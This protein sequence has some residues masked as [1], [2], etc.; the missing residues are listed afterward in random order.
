MNILY[1]F[2]YFLFAHSLTHTI[3]VPTSSGSWPTS[4]SLI[5]SF[6]V[7]LQCIRNG[8]PHSTLPKKL[9]S[10]LL[11]DDRYAIRTSCVLFVP[12]G[13]RLP[14]NLGEVQGLTPKVILPCRSSHLTLTSLSKFRTKLRFLSHL[15]YAG[16]RPL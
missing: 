12:Y 13:L 2:S 4:L 6:G 15:A 7:A 1:V 11:Y 8:C 3:L 14:C 16:F 9:L 5:L 10:S